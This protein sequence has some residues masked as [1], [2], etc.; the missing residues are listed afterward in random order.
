MGSLLQA[1]LQAFGL[2][3]CRGAAEILFFS[4]RH[5][6]MPATYRQVAKP[7][8][9]RARGEAR[10][11]ELASAREVAAGL[12]LDELVSETLADPVR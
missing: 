1:L 7:T 9:G 11:R 12:D 3:T 4:L 10:P 2:E 8:L 6:A 5:E